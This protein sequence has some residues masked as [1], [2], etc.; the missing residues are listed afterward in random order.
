MVTSLKEFVKAHKCPLC[1]LSPEIR[2]EVD[3]G[4][5][6]G[7]GVVLIARW[8]TDVQGIKCNASSVQNHRA[9]PG[10]KHDPA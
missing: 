9:N 4:I 3:Q 1:A 5:A 6:E 2:A 7:L 8:L 10:G